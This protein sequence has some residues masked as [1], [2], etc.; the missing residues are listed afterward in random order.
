MSNLK[1]QKDEKLEKKDEKLEKLFQKDSTYIPKVGDVIEGEIISSSKSGIYLDINGLTVGVVRGRELYNELEEY[2][3][4]KVGDRV[5]AIVLELENERGEMELSFKE[6]GQ[7]KAWDNLFDLLKKKETVEVKV[8]EA[9]KGG[10]IVKIGP[11]AGFLPVS[12]LSPVHYPRVDGGNKTKI[13]EKLKKLIDEKINVVIIDIQ[14]KEEKIIVSEKET[15]EIKNKIFNKYKIGDIVEGK[16]KEIVDFGI[17]VEF[18]EGLEGLVHISE[19][20]WQRIDST[21]DF[22]KVGSKIKV[23]IMGH[24]NFRFA[25]SIKK[26]MRNPWEE[27]MENYKI[28]QIVKGKVL[29][30]NPFGAFIELNKD[31]QGLLHLSEFSDNPIKKAS[32]VLEIGQILNFKII[33]LDP[34]SYRL[35]F[36]LK[37]V[38]QDSL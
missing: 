22:I 25:L 37:G 4:L 3:N 33:S 23:K 29:K 6:A 36:S 19:L 21:K 5:S 13:L 14:E 1:N 12:Q 9:N 2:A 32:D 38:E 15:E 24:K 8:M 16:V 18:D 20:A 26:T 30:F 27:A 10:L 11:I 31:I 34:R 35:G 17:F 7:K 28:G